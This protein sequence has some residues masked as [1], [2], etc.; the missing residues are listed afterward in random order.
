MSTLNLRCLNVRALTETILI[1]TLLGENTVFLALNI[2][3]KCMTG[4]WE[5]WFDN[6]GIKA[7][8]FTD[9]KKNAYVPNIGQKLAIAGAG[10]T[11]APSRPATP[12][13]LSVLF[14]LTRNVVTSNFYHSDRKEPGRAPEARMGLDLI[15]DWMNEHDEI[16]IGNIGE[17]LF[18]LKLADLPS[19]DEQIAFEIAK[20]CNRSALFSQ[21]L[22]AKGRPSKRISTREEFVRNPFIVRAALLRAN[23]KCE[24]PDCTIKLFKKTDHTTYL[25]VHHITPLSEGGNDSIENAAAVCP[26]CHRELHHGF[27]QNALRSRLQIEVA[28]KALT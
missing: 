14:D 3:G 12:F 18:A 19:T 22:K 17:Q 21:A 7:V 25:E 6:F 28:A 26:S 20:Y 23:G 8:G 27:E 5:S 16:L 10:I 11:P 24:T 13:S 2:K 4:K 1:V 9:K 15:T